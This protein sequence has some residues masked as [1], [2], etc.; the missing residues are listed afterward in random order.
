MLAL[1]LAPV[2][3]AAA[4]LAAHFY[5]A[6]AIVPLVITL[7]ALALPFVRRRW[8]ARALQV[9]LVLGALEWL[10]TLALLVDARRTTG[11]PYLR[12][13][14]ILGA[15]AVATALTTVVFR[16]RAVRR[17]FRLAANDDAEGPRGV[18]AAAHR[19]RSRAQP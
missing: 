13:A 2:A 7:S 6:G 16:S 5:R 12:L 4:V 1:R 17:H 8:A 3:V 15:V 9:G 10:R 19:P 14:L 11:Q 18:E